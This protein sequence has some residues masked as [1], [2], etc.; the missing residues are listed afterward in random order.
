ME[1]YLNR[2][3]VKGEATSNL[4]SEQQQRGNRL[5]APDQIKVSNP[6]CCGILSDIT[7]FLYKGE[8]T[9]KEETRGQRVPWTSRV[10]SMTGDNPQDVFCSFLPVMMGLPE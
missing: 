9:R 5:T 4:L 3:S 6:V 10:S 7:F 2:E 8:G 1:I